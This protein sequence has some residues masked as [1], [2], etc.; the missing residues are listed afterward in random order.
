MLALDILLLVTFCVAMIIAPIAWL[1]MLKA[2]N[3]SAYLKNIAWFVFPI[4]A[5]FVLGW[6][7]G[8]FDQQ[9]PSPPQRVE[10]TATEGLSWVQVALLSLAGATWIVGGSLLWFRH[11]KRVGRPWWTVMNPL[12]PQFRDFTSKEWAALGGLA[13]VALSLGAIAINLGPPQ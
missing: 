8:A 2:K 6:L 11:T 13:F 12:Q 3:Q 7:S 1:R 4:L 9:N 5:V 10:T